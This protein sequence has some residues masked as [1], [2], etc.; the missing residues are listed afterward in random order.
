MTIAVWPT[1]AQTQITIANFMLNFLCQIW[2]CS[3]VILWQCNVLFFTE[4]LFNAVIHLNIP[5]I[6]V[7]I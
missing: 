6:P 3:N 4:G 5:K 1:F 2:A 7:K